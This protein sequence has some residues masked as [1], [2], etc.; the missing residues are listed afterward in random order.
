[1]NRLSD[2]SL[3]VAALGLAA[4]AWMIGFP[5]QRARSYAVRVVYWPGTLAVI[6]EALAGLVAW[7]LLIALL[8]FVAWLMRGTSIEPP[9]TEQFGEAIEKAP[10]GLRPF[11]LGTLIVVGP[12]AEELFFR[13]FLFNALRRKLTTGPAVVLQAVLFGLG[14]S[15]SPSY[16]FV[17]FVMGLFLAA[18]YIYRRSL[19]TTI[20]IHASQ[21][22]LAVLVAWALSHA[23]AEVPILGIRGEPSADGYVVRAVTPDGPADRAGLRPRDVI[24]TVDGYRVENLA[25]VRGVLQLHRVGDEVRITYLRAGEPNSCLAVLGRRLG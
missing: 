14:H 12:V 2:D 23:A 21:N 20:F 19:L 9:R 18:V 10:G 8:F 22:L 13:G 6:R 7:I 17:T 25:H 4:L 11:L 24:T 16:M 3:L 1:M 5:L 15:Y